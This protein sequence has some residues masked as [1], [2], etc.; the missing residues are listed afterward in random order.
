MEELQRPE[1][2]KMEKRKEGRT[3]W[4]CKTMTTTKIAIT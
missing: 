2:G 1:K 3:T 4:E